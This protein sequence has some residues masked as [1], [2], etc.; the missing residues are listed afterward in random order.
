MCR[1]GVVL[2]GL[3]MAVDMG[4]G[5]GASRTGPPWTGSVEA[6][7]ST[8]AFTLGL[9]DLRAATGSQCQAPRIYVQ[10][11]A[12]M[13]T[14]KLYSG[15]LGVGDEILEV[16]GAKVAGLGLAHIKELLACSESLSIQTGT[17]VTQKCHCPHC[18]R[19]GSPEPL[20]V[21][22]R[23]HAAKLL[24]AGNMDPAGV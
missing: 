7:A 11:M 6:E 16:N 23:E 24:C 2:L 8:G 18:H 4:E 12:D 3:G 1:R 21:V 9:G 13:S 10:E 15:L 19:I 20:R 17:T 22:G 5:S 14:A